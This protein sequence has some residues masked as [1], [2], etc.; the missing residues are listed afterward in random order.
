MRYAVANIADF[1]ERA[2]RVEGRP[3]IRVV[4][5]VRYP[6]KIFYRIVQCVENRAHPARRTTPLDRRCLET[7]RSIFPHAAA[8]ISATIASAT[9]LG[10]SAA[11]TGRPTT[12]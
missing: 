11:I 10:S 3:G 9:A 4:P 12:R 7:P 5:L 2:A 6:F 8:A 1:P